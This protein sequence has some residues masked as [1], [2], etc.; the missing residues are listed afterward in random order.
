VRCH[1]YVAAKGCGRSRLRA[2][3]PSTMDKMNFAE[4]VKLLRETAH[5]LRAAADIVLAEVLH[6]EAAAERFKQRVSRRTSARRAL[7]TKPRGALRGFLPT[8]H[9]P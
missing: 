4:R 9:L 3:T 6:M 7:T 2:N 5:N 8:S 1:K